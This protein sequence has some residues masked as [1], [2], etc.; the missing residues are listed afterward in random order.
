MS[1]SLWSS[2]RSVAAGLCGRPANRRPKERPRRRSNGLGFEALEPREMM[3]VNFEFNYSLDTS[4]FFTQERRDLLAYAGTMITAQLNDTLS[5][6][7]PSGSNTWSAKITNPATGADKTISNASLPADVIRVYAGARNIDNGNT[8]ARAGAGG[9]SANGTTAWL[10][11]VEGRGEAGALLD[12]PTDTA[13]KIGHITFDTSPTWHFGRT[14]D[15]LA[16]NETDFVSVAMHELGHVLGIASS[17]SGNSWT[18]LI[19]GGKFTGSKA[20]AENNGVSPAASGG[21]FAEGVKSDGLE[22]AM[23]P[24]INSGTRKLYSEL[25]FAALDD[26]GWERKETEDVDFDDSIYR[27]RHQLT[28]FLPEGGVGGSDAVAM[29]RSIVSSK[30][31]DIYRVWGEKGTELS[32][33]VSRPNGA[34]AFDTYIRL[35]N[36]AGTQVKYGDQGGPGGTDSL[37]YKLP[38]SDYYYIGVSSYGNRTYKPGTINSGPGGATG[39]YQVG[40]SMDDP[41]VGGLQADDSVAAKSAKHGKQKGTKVSDTATGHGGSANHALALAQQADEAARSHSRKARE[42][43]FAQ[44]EMWLGAI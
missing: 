25:D 2:V 10:N 14:T 34:A 38:R 18:R 44:E 24:S 36:S 21:H 3:T 37:E 8:L 23:D 17:T 22:V 39:S 20:T 29:I 40:I 16:S 41:A 9:W 6:I 7:T 11:T 43:A 32:A 15:G 31:V 26:I 33:S 1:A 30:D 35:F 19:S 12:S 13:P 42:V 28:H 5:A 27:A 4:G